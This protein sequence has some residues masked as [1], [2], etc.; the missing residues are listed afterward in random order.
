[1]PEALFELC[2]SADGET[3]CDFGKGGR[4]WLGAPRMRRVQREN[5]EKPPLAGQSFVV[6]VKGMRPEAPSL[7]RILVAAGANARTEH[8]GLRL[9][10]ATI[11]V[12]P[13]SATCSTHEIAA[14]AVEQGITCVTSD[15]ILEQITLHEPRS[16]QMAAADLASELA[17]CRD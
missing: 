5:G 3:E 13:A 7:Q 17:A 14:R 12:L 16:L 1:L 15:W 9:D 2:E 4:L 6:A 11:V 8:P 10:M